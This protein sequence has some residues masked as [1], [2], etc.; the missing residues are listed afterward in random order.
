MLAD[1]VD[2]QATGHRRGGEE[3]PALTTIASIGG[4]MLLARLVGGHLA[5]HTSSVS[6]RPG[7]SRPPLR[8]R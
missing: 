3:P 5:G 8:I 7:A 4:E 6:N 2:I 1:V